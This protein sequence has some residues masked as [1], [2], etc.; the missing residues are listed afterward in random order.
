M[1]FD[2]SFPIV[3][4]ILGVS[5]C[6]PGA[7]DPDSTVWVWAVDCPTAGNVTVT[8]TGVNLVL[9]LTVVIGSVTVNT[10][11]TSSPD[12][13]QLLVTLPAGTGQALVLS[14]RSCSTLSFLL[15]QE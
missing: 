6:A 15:L 5:G 9:P 3:P 10:P 12:N 13:T 7:V 14:V 8:I 1:L 4:Q 2:S 11:V